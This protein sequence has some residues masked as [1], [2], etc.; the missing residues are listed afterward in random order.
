MKWFTLAFL[1]CPV[2]LPASHYEEGPGLVPLCIQ[3]LF[4]ATL[5]HSP[6][7]CGLQEH[8]DTCQSFFFF[9][10]QRGV[11]GSAENTWH[12][13]PLEAAGEEEDGG[14]GVLENIWS[15]SANSSVIAIIGVRQDIY[16]YIKGYVC[17][18]FHL[19]NFDFLYFLLESSFHTLKETDSF[20]SDCGPSQTKAI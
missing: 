1:S 3:L 11:R 6:T 7:V 15:V 20:M 4:P 9:Q 10:K 2:L 13:S 17:L 16:I 14:E 12:L 19:G 8:T 5:I 18:L